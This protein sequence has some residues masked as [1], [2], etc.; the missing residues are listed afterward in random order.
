MNFHHSI[1]ITN[2][3]KLLE[4]Q[5][6]KAQ[7][8]LIVDD[9]KL[10][11]KMQTEIKLNCDDTLNLSKIDF[12]LVTAGFIRGVIFQNE[13]HEIDQKMVVDIVTV[14]TKYV[15]NP[16]LLE[17]WKDPINF[18]GESDVIQCQRLREQGN[19]YFK[20]KEYLT[21]VVKYNAAIKHNPNNYLI[22]AN[23]GLTHQHLGNFERAFN[24][25]RLSIIIA[26]FYPKNWYR[27]G[28]LLLKCSL[29]LSSCIDISGEDSSCA[30]F[31]KYYPITCAKPNLKLACVAFYTGFAVL[32]N[33]DQ[34]QMKGI[35]L[36]LKNKIAQVPEN[37][38]DACVGQGISTE[39]HTEQQHNQVLQDQKGQ[40]NSKTVCLGVN[41]SA[42]RSRSKSRNKNSFILTKLNKNN[43]CYKQLMHVINN[44]LPKYEKNNS[45]KIKQTINFVLDFDDKIKKDVIDQIDKTTDNHN[46][47]VISKNVPTT[48]LFLNDLYHAR[49]ESKLL[50]YFKNIGKQCD[51]NNNQFVSDA[52]QS[53]LESH[54]VTHG[55]QPESQLQSRKNRQLS[56][57]CYGWI[58]SWTSQNVI[59]NNKRVF[60]T[61]IMGQ[62]RLDFQQKT[63]NYYQCFGKPSALMLI[64]FLLKTMV[65]TRCSLELVGKPRR[66]DFA[67]RFKYCFNT[68][69]DEM[70]KLGIMC[71]LTPKSKETLND[72]Q[73]HQTHPDGWNHL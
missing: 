52:C 19:D 67:N 8:I 23:R 47:S 45:V 9:Q 39:K 31:T 42:K 35:N 69:R 64:L 53:E 55:P 21:A 18:I 49:H 26:P 4:Y 12:S 54:L 20:K 14:I 72:G 28:L 70:K 58:V 71:F 32:E 51:I 61:V 29:T 30:N 56:N 40:K 33:W 17:P 63:L 16:F 25:I 65:F 15:K 60:G 3:R 2:Q 46:P 50:V 38:D 7:Y 48:I 37:N 13:Q 36:L 66:I 1:R 73:Q 10:V 62:D 11:Y 57:G 43:Q 34:I 22:L 68:V 27:L 24:D 59:M 44:I 6:S 5:F 41:M